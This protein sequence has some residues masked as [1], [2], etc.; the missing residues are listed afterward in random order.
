MTAFG[1]LTAFAESD[2]FDQ[3]ETTS[4][5]WYISGSDKVEEVSEQVGTSLDR[6]ETAKFDYIEEKYTVRD[7]AETLSNRSRGFT[8]EESKGYGEFLKSIFD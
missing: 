4:Y 6:G 1:H 8:K 3:T 7:L 2:Q 5:P